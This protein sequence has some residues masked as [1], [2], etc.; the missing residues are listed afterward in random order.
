MSKSV[1]FKPHETYSSRD[2]KTV[3][4]IVCALIDSIKNCYFFHLRVPSQADFYLRTSF[5]TG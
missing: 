2:V 4:E 3:L 5:T 1:K